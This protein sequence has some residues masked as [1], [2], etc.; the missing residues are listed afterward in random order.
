MQITERKVQGEI[1]I[2]VAVK[3]EKTKGKERQWL[4]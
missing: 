4:I 2:R 1:W 3:E